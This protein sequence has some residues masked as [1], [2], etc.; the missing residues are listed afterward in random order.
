MKINL[1]KARRA[2][3]N[4]KIGDYIFDGVASFIHLRT[5]LNNTNQVP[6]ETD[7]RVIDKTG[8]SMQIETSSDP[9]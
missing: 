1:S 3:K 2:T 5:D 7:K 9:K 6:E 4:C 8:Y